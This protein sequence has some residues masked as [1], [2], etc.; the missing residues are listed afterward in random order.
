[1]ADVTG[2]V[3]SLPGSAH[4]VPSGTMCDEHNDVPAVAR[5]QGETD[6]FG[7]EFYDVCQAC[8]DR[9]REAAKNCDPSGHCD[10][11]KKHAPRVSPHR[12]FEEGLSGPVYDV[13][14]ACIKAQSDRIREELDAQSDDWHDRHG[15][16][17]DDDDDCG[18]TPEEVAEE[19][20]YQ[21]MLD[22]ESREQMARQEVFHLLLHK[23]TD[24]KWILRKHAQK[25]DPRRDR[26]VLYKR[27]KYSTT[28]VYID[29]DKEKVE[30]KRMK[31]FLASVHLMSL[32]KWDE[33]YPPDE[34]IWYFCKGN[35]YRCYMATINWTYQTITYER[36]RIK[37]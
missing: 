28:F 17:D 6:S 36:V 19:E 5:I 13:C 18:M 24:R 9:D 27:G 4:C 12:D 3:R 34:G 2:P 20:A 8:L 33:P 32:L 10:W 35:K 31:S 37:Q 14:D 16:P 11:C 22:Q 21:D 15:W 26:S 25:D 29:F 30:F 1:M 7:A 23:L